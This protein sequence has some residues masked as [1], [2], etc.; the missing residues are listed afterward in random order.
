MNQKRKTNKPIGPGCDVYDPGSITLIQAVT[1]I[2]AAIPKPTRSK[3]LKLRKALGRV[4]SQDI[5][6]GAD[7]PNHTNSAMDGFAFSSADLNSEGFCQL[8]VNGSAYAGQALLRTGSKGRS[9]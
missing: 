6:A 2:L 9:G 8:R 7:V 3:K 1:Q 4:L 5:V